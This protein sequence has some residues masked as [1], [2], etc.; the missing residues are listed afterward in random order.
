MVSEIAV[1]IYAIAICTCQFFLTQPSLLLL[2]KFLSR[3]ALSALVIPLQTFRLPPHKDTFTSVT[4]FSGQ[5][6]EVA[7]GV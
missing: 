4:N 7:L 2:Q 3:P 5:T 1:V 6:M